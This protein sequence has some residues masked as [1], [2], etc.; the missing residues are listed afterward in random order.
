MNAWTF[1]WLTEVSPEWIG[2]KLGTALSKIEKA[3]PRPVL[4]IDKK[5]GIIRRI[6]PSKIRGK[7]NRIIAK[8]SEYNKKKYTGKILDH[9]KGRFDRAFDSGRGVKKAA[10][11]PPAGAS[12]SGWKE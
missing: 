1:K 7:Y 4:T 12:M 5:A 10:G 6:E 9:M 11:G 3:G 8:S 2:H